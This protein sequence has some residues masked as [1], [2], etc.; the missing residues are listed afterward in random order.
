MNRSALAVGL[1]SVGADSEVPDAGA[2][3]AIEWIVE[4]YPEPCRWEP[5]N[6]HAVLQENATARLGTPRR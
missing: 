1:G 5:L 4:R 2:P 3:Q 6:G